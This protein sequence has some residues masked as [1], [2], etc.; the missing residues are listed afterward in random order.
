MITRQETTTTYTGPLVILQGDSVTLTG[1]LLEEGVT[2]IQ[3][4]T[5]TLKLGS[6]SCTGVTNANGDASCALFVTVLL[7][8]QAL[9][10]E[11]AGDGFYLPSADATAQAIVFAFPARGA[12]VLGDLTVAAATPSTSLTWWSQSWTAR[13]SV[14]GGAVNPSF[15]GFA[16]ALG[17]SP[18]VC[19][20]TWTTST[21]NSPPPVGSVPSYM[22]VL[23]TSA[24][25][26]P[27]STVSGNA[28]K[29]VVVL[30]QPGYGPNPGSQGTGTV[31]ATYCP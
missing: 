31:V 13:N 30:T 11:F 14:S 20:S 5:L 28:V 6:Q 17:S 27:G 21:G 29:I 19:G 4:R 15:K 18:P 23:V 12:F 25:T 22:G 26:T 3:G 10:A 8:P 7:G 16:H 9:G 2:P 1:R 24:V